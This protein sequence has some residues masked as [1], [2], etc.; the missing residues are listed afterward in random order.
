[1][2][3][4]LLPT[5]H[6]PSRSPVS[7]YPASPTFNIHPRLPSN[8]TSR[9]ESG[10]GGRNGTTIGRVPVIFRRLLKFSQMDWE[11]AAWQ[12]TWLC[13]AP[14]R[15]YRN[16]YF[17]KVKTK[18][19]W[20]RDD[21]AILILISACLVVSAA[22]WSFVHSYPL[23][24][25]LKYALLMIFR[26]FL[27]VGALVATCLWFLSN[28]LLLQPLT[29]HTAEEI[30]K[31]E[32]AYAFDVHTNAFFPLYLSLY[33]AQ[34]FL[35]PVITKDNWICLWVGNSLYLASLAQYTYI[36][37][38][39]FNALPFLI[40]S[41][42]ILFPLIPLFAAYLVSLLGFNVSKHVLDAYFRY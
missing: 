26:D 38:L 10:T 27:A 35:A 19:V 23:S 39:G 8:N 12:L 9:V 2:T 11:L 31:V 15:V 33:L 28:K 5:T 29:N 22:A 32:W 17:H 3:S 7:V 1:M 24:G 30:P 20:A 4:N 37:Y 18:N 25:I 41:E 21:P 14:K 6:L 36:T 34:L 16:V 40:R 13:I 42:L